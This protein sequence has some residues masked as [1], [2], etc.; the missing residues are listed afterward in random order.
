MCHWRWGPVGG[1]GWLEMSLWREHS[2]LVLSDASA[3][4]PWS[5]GLAFEPANQQLKHLKLWAEF[6]FSTFK[7]WVSGI[8]FLSIGKL[9]YTRATGQALS[10]TILT[11]SLQQWHCHYS[12][13][14]VKLRQSKVINITIVKKIIAMTC[15][16]TR[17]KFYSIAFT[18]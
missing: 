13:A 1:G 16:H 8:F 3:L 2:S 6:N 17:R 11:T 9:N 10:F 14:S 15:T 5:K 4:P 18:S 7:L 12:L